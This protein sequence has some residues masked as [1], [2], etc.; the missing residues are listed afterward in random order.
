MVSFFI[1]SPTREVK[2]RAGLPTRLTV[3][4]IM[5]TISEL[6]NQIRDYINNPRK[7][8]TLLK[9]SA[10]WFKLCSSLDTI[11]DT[12]LALD[13]YAGIAEPES[14][15][16]KY[17]ML[18]GVLQV[19]FVQ[20]DAVTH[21]AEALDIPYTVDPVIT[22]IREVRNDSI[23]H[24]TKRGGG[25]GRAFNFISRISMS[26]G[27]FTLMTS[28]AAAADTKFQHINIPQLVESQRVI[29]RTTLCAVIEK[30]K[31]EEMKHREEFEGKKLSEAFPQTLSYYFGKM[32]EAIH[33]SAPR[34]FGAAHLKFVAE[35]VESFKSALSER[36]LLD[37]YD[38]ITYELNLIEYPM[39]ELGKFFENPQESR[40]NA[41]DAYIFMFFVKKHIDTLIT[42]A[43]EIDE[44]Y[45]SEP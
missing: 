4:K 27:G 21:L 37:A 15:G 30:L 20:Q 10:A 12:E 11:G 40:L 7:Q 17:L 1:S 26:K 6:E 39:S 41:Q 43:G 34:E 32:D 29:L 5:Q 22:E 2:A 18:Y 24:P 14:D 33:G 38:S 23:G 42:I 25:K 19:L 31:E 45:A 16:E 13:A 44:E 9:D 36:D 8:H 35:T 3:L 28:Y